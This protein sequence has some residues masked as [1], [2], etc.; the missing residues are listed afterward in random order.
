[1]SEGNNLFCF[2]LCLKRCAAVDVKEKSAQRR[3][4][5]ENGRATKRCI[6]L[7]VPPLS[8]SYNLPALGALRDKFRPVPHFFSVF[9]LCSA[10]A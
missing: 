8:L 9:P 2:F 4:L 6:H 5:Y 10:I 7:E 3:R 1:M